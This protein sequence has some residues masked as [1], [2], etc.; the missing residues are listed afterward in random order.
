MNLPH[1]VV[2]QEVQHGPDVRLHRLGGAALDQ[3]QVGLVAVRC[4]LG[5]FLV[6]GVTQGV[7]GFVSQQKRANAG[8][9]LHLGQEAALSPAGS[10]AR[11]VRAVAERR[12]IPPVP[13]QVDPVPDRPFAVQAG[14]QSQAFGV[15]GEFL[16]QHFTPPPWM[17]WEPSAH[18]PSVRH[19]RTVGWRS[20]SHPEG[21]PFAAA[22]SPGPR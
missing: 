3:G 16:Q 22:Y 21:N 14:P 10:R 18:R 7:I 11:R 2:A 20:P 19:G 13:V 15:L 9:S 1:R 17:P 12:E 5:S 6:R 8:R 4:P